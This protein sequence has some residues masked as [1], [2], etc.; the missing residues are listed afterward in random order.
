[1]N[2]NFLEL[3]DKNNNNF[4]EN[5]L[6]N[7]TEQRKKVIEQPNQNLLFQ[8]QDKIPT[9][10]NS[11][12]DAMRGT[13]YDTPLSIAFFSSENQEILQNGIRKGV[14]DMSQKEYVIDRQD[15]DSLK[16]IMR[17]IFL[18][19]SVND[20]NNI[21]QQI[22][23]LN[24]LVLHYAIHKVFGEVQSYKKYRRDIDNLPMPIN[25]PVNTKKSNQVKFT[26]F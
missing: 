1:M 2:F 21:T 13:F 9:E 4:N 26:F 22:V 19:H 5:D 15:P 23:T 7:L 8:M 16:M 18:Q 6:M 3:D 20:P 17:S 12:N 25:R 14:Y 10:S 24:S 11:F